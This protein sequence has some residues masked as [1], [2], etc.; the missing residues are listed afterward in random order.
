MI[1]QVSDNQPP[2]STARWIVIQ[3]V[4][5]L[6]AI[7]GVV[8]GLFFYYIDLGHYPPQEWLGV[9]DRELASDAGTA[10][11]MPLMLY[12][13]CAVIGLV[14][15]YRAIAQNQRANTGCLSVIGVSSCSR[16]ASP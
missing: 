15:E 10:S 8:V 5:W 1:Y 2:L 14:K 3:I 13:P 7:I 11:L 4:T 12:L 6:T 16:Y 9:I